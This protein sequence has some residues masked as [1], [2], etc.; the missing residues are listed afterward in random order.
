MNIERIQGSVGYM[1]E[2]QRFPL[3][4]GEFDRFLGVQIKNWAALHHAP[5]DSYINLLQQICLIFG[6]N[7]GGNTGKVNPC[8]EWGDE[9]D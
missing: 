3:F 2:A 9:L 4:N 6:C 8:E 1:V 7:G 5:E